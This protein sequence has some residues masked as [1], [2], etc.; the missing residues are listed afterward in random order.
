MD[1]H[2]ELSSDEKE[3]FKK[4]ARKNWKIDE[5]VNPIWHPVVVNECAVMLDEEIRKST[6]KYRY[7]RSAFNF[8]YKDITIALD[9]STDEISEEE[10]LEMAIE[11]FWEVKW[12]ELTDGKS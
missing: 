5:K 6:Y 11:H 12:E 2:R 8:A 10:Q 4:W 1:L 9:S 3:S 7:E